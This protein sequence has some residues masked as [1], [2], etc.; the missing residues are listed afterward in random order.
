MIDLES[1]AAEA[2]EWATRLDSVKAQGFN[3]IHARQGRGELRTSAYNQRWMA[4][5]HA[6]GLKV[7]LHSWQQPPDWRSFSRNYW[8]RVFEAE[9]THLFTYATGRQIAHGDTT[10]R[11]AA[12]GEHAAGLLLASQRS[13]YLRRNPPDRQG[14]SS[15]FGHHVFRLRSDGNSGRNDHIA[16]LRVLLRDGTV[17]DSTIVRGRD[18]PDNTYRPFPLEYDIGRGP[19]RPVPVRY[20]VHWTGADTLWVD[21]IRAHDFEI[22]DGDTLRPPRADELF[23]GERDDAIRDTLAAYSADPPWRFALYDEPRWSAT[24]RSRCGPTCPGPRCRCRPPPV[25]GRCA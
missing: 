19:G 21:H 12:T 3:T 14:Y 23:R 1:E 25:T 6:R 20:Q 11:Y 7:Q 15:R 13:V 5:A 10:A 2:A 22:D 24:R 17:M 4:L 8:T 9:D 16:T 18:L